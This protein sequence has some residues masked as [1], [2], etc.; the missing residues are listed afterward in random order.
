MSSHPFV[1]TRVRGEKRG[2][3]N[4]ST[5]TFRYRIDEQSDED[6]ICVRIW[7]RAVA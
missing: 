4:R 6:I 1:E 2:E 7:S 5:K 3:Y